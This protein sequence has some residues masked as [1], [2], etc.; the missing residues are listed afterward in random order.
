MCGPC[1]DSQEEEVDRGV[2]IEVMKLI[3]VV[4]GSKGSKGQVLFE[5]LQM[6]A[7]CWDANAMSCASLFFVASVKSKRI[8]SNACTS[9]P[10]KDASMHLGWL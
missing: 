2:V 3:Q 6:V 4:N 10:G 7:A 8:Y 9:R 5:A 1:W